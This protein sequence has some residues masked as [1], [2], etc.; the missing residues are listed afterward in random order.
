MDALQ[1]AGAHRSA[2]GQ[3]A[4]RAHLRSQFRGP[5]E[6]ERR[7]R[8]ARLWR[9]AAAAPVPHRQRHLR[10]VRCPLDA[11]LSDSAVLS[12]PF[13]GRDRAV[14]RAGA[15]GAGLVRPPA[16]GSAGAGR[17]P[18][19][20]RR[21][22]VPAR[23]AAQRRGARA[24]GHG[25]PPAAALGRQIPRGAGPAGHGPGAHAPHHGLEQI[26]PLL[27]AVAGPGCG[28][29]AGDQPPAVTRRDD[30]RQRADDAHPGAHRP[31]GGHLARLHLGAR[32]VCAPRSPAA[33]P[34]GARSPA[35]A[36]R[37]P[38]R[39]GTARCRGPCRAARAAHPAGREPGAA[40][41][42]GHRHS[43]PVGLG[44]VDA[45]ALHHRCLAPRQRR[46]AA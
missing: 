4:G 1:G 9:S 32:R 11:D 31:A 46:S 7:R 8:A 22:F 18:G 37:A 3:P 27:A 38:G 16:G 41:G 19:A 43:W 10:A 23:Q 29:A 13:A 34:P 17:K 14:L 12:A 20:G 5:P 2:A 26:H 25:A 6:Q 42:F 45:G 44:Q 15:G 40:A 28:R 21:P 36:Q 30:C 24:H 39:A 35:A 33:Q